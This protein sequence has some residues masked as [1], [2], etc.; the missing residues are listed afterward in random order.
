MTKEIA[1]ENSSIQD[2]NNKKERGK[3]TKAMALENSSVQIMNIVKEKWENGKK[4]LLWKLVL[5]RS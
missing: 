3:R 4:K 2:M 1:L 5:F